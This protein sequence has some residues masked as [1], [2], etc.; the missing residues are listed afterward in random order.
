MNKSILDNKQSITDQWAAILL[1]GIIPCFE[2]ELKGD[3]WLLVDLELID[4]KEGLFLKFSF[5]SD[6]MRTSFDGDIIKYNNDFYGIKIDLE[7][8][9]NLDILLEHINDNI[10][11]GYILPNGLYPDNDE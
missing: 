8:D 2:Y 9:N 1:R 11:E 10:L 4:N 6:G 3:E 5:D 7:Y